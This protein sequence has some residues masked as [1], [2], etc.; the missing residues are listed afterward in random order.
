MPA[1]RYWRITGLAL[2]GQGDLTVLDIGL[3]SDDVRVDAT[4]THT[5]SLAPLSGTTF[6]ATDVAKS[7][8]AFVWDFGRAQDVDDAQFTLGATSAHISRYQIESSEDGHIWKTEFRWRGLFGGAPLVQLPPND[9][10][11]KK[12]L[13]YLDARDSA[14]GCLAY[15]GPDFVNTGTVPVSLSNSVSYYPVTSRFISATP[16]YFGQITSAAKAMEYTLSGDFSVEMRIARP[17]A[18]TS[19]PGILCGFGSTGLRL[20]LHPSFSSGYPVSVGTA[21][22]TTLGI[23]SNAISTNAP[24]TVKWIRNSGTHRLVVDGSVRALFYDDTPIVFDRIVVGSTSSSGQF[25]YFSHLRV[26]D[27]VDRG[28]DSSDVLGPLEGPDPSSV[29]PIGSGEV[30]DY[31]PPDSP[32]Q[33]GLA[34]TQIDTVDGGTVSVSG[35]VKKMG[36]PANLPLRRRVRLYHSKDRRFIRETWSDPDTGEFSFTGL[37]AGEEMHLIAHDHEHTYRALVRDKVVGT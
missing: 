16:G 5:A 21:G 22:G 19:Q 11:Y 23:A 3:Y 13:A 24:S 35:T 26:T 20:Y 12:V 33:L 1:A 2:H 36:L 29:L 17:S 15:R 32:A 9:P 30:G 14:L 25:F 31:A 7:G 27:G 28:N 8:F 37:K 34:H 18:Q 6:A 10:H 4:A